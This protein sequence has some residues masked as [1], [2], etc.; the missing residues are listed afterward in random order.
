MRYLIHI[1]LM[2]LLLPSCFQEEDMVFPHEQGD[3]EVGQ[4]AQGTS[5]ERQVYYDLF[6]NDE[7][8]S[9]FISEY[10]LS[11]ES[12]SEGWIIR[13]NSSKFM[14]AGNSGD[15]VFSKEIAAADLDMIF[16]KSDGNPDSTAIGAWFEI[17]E[18]FAESHRYVYLVDRGKNEKNKSV[19]L[20]KVQFE[21]SGDEY[22]M[23]YANRD[24]SR[25]T[26]VVIPRDPDMDQVYFSFDSGLKEIAP[27]PDLWSLL[28]SKYT[29]ML[30]TDEG[31]DYPYLVTG[32]LLNPNTVLAVR[33]T[34]HD[35][36]NITRENIIG[37][38]FTEQSD[39]IG[40]DWKYY[41][42]DAGVYTIV[43]DMNYVIRDRDGFFYK[44]RFIDFNN[45]M[46]EKGYP[47]IEFVR[48]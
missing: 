26:T 2:A 14:L 28:F 16:D 43:S 39:V 32:V 44:L 22:V 3:L 33:D 19:G 40:Y 6:S 9:N 41:N 35:F 4:A 10:D 47:T 27:L 37:L 30:Q 1:L 23:R 38:G 31:E 45:D 25:D 36:M 11:F 12:S 15:T 20:K 29:T 42:F 7:I 18:D 46:G 5:Y 34:I 24:N 17:S 13:L 48:L 8:S 21:I